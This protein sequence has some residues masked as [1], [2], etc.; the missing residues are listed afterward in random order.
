[1]QPGFQ[2]VFYPGAHD[3]ADPQKGLLT[4]NA[5]VCERPC[6]IDDCRHDFS[7]VVKDLQLDMPSNL[8][9]TPDRQAQNICEVRLIALHPGEDP[10][11]PRAEEAIATIRPNDRLVADVLDEPIDVDVAAARF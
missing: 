11:R 10:F 6:T 9:G 5:S 3:V 7:T 8:H 4:K 2:Y 1:M